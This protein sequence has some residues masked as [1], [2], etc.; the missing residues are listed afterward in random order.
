MVTSG[1]QTVDAW[2]PCPT[3]IIPILHQP[4]P[5]DLNKSSIDAAL[6]TLLVYSHQTDIM[7][8]DFE[9]HRY[10]PPPP[11]FLVTTFCLPDVIC[12]LQAINDWRWE[13]PGN[14]L[15]MAWERP[16]NDLGMAWEQPGN[17]L[18][19]AWER[20]GNSLGMAWERGVT[21]YI[22]LAITRPYKLP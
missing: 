17:G 19:M 18:R 7:R 1:R 8:K 16:G 3:V 10:C 21:I 2:E 13:W 5:A 20:P 14:G 11:A 22:M 9:I 4:I 12:I 6:Q 15:G